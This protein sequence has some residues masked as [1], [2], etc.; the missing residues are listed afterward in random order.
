MQIT[1]DDFVRGVRN[2]QI[3]AQ[4]HTQRHELR[5]FKAGLDVLKEGLAEEQSEINKLRRDF[6]FA[7]EQK[8]SDDIEMLCRELGRVADQSEV[9]MLRRELEYVRAAIRG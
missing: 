5:N 1:L 3:Q 2:A 7:R 6:G 9:E 8:L 4:I